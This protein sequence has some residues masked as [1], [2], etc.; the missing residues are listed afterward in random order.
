MGTGGT[1]AGP[2]ERQGI[3]PRLAFELFG[4]APHAGEVKVNVSVLEIYGE[5]LRDLL[6]DDRETKLLVRQD[7]RGEI[8][9]TGLTQV[10]VGSAESLLNVL[11][12]GAF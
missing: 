2:S 9:V 11:N 4:R 12:K 3:V 7:E 1:K 6:V 8:F 5:E 10:P